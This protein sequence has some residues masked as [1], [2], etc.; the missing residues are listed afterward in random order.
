MQTI[1]WEEVHNTLYTK[2]IFEN[3]AQAIGFIAKVAVIA[4]QQ[5][6][7]PTITNT[8]NKVELWLSTHDA[9][10]TVTDKDHQLATAITAI[11]Q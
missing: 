3:F 2:I 11:L 8:Y 6:H 4:E 5:N 9:G 7:H 1:S 10:N